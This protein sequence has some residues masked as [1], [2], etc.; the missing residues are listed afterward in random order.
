MSEFFFF[1]GGGVCWCSRVFVFRAGLI[2]WKDCLRIVSLFVCYLPYV[3]TCIESFFVFSWSP[4]G[5]CISLEARQCILER[6]ATCTYP[7]RTME[8]TAIYTSPAKDSETCTFADP[9]QGCAFW[10]FAQVAPRFSCSKLFGEGWS[11]KHSCGS[12]TMNVDA[13]PS[14]RLCFRDAPGLP[15]PER[16]SGADR[17]RCLRGGGPVLPQPA[18]ALRGG[19]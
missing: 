4:C 17:K 7:K 19:G 11:T 12:Y 9:F 5:L 13:P 18:A 10:D 3:Y 16:W 6:S 15:P 1:L 8:K 14:L 2:Q